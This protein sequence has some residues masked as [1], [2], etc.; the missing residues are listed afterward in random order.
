MARLRWF[1]AIG[2]VLLALALV[3]A[4]LAVRGHQAAQDRTREV[5]RQALASAAQAASFR[6]EPEQALALALAAIDKDPAHPPDEVTAI[7]YQGATRRRF[8][9]HTDAVTSVA[10]SPDGKTALSTSADQTL[11]L[12]NVATGQPIRTFQGHTDFV[13]SVAFSPD[14][15]TA[16]SASEDT[17]LR[18]WPVGTLADQIAFVRANRYVPALS[19]AQRAQYG[20]EPLCPAADAAATATAP[21]PATLTP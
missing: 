4:V 2:G 18:L 15:K 21:A 19:C 3:A 17:T 8:S 14:G 13:T 16:L 11:R 9:G 10:F 7:V 1:L 6:G 5:Q 20:V 12:W